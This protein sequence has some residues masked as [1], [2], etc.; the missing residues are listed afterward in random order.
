MRVRA[1]SY[2]YVGP[3]DLKDAAT[4]ETEGPRLRSYA[5]INEWLNSRPEEELSE[6]FTFVVDPEGFLRLAAR[7]S[8]HVVCAGG[9]LVLSAGEMG[10]ERSDG[11]WAVTQV[12]NQSTGYCPDAE[13]W[14]AVAAALDRA[15]IG[16]PAGFTAEITFRRC[17]GC[18]EVNVVRE[19][20]FACALCDADLPEHWNVD[21]HGWDAG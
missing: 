7:R 17:P 13:S 18:R 5:D 21:G 15:G 1:R 20:G 11:A 4:T 2:R 16:H 3:A 10:F 9:G 8:E 19:G 6:P 12:S 14:P